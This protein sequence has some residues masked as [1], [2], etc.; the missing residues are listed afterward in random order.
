MKEVD[1][2]GLQLEPIQNVLIVVLGEQDEPK[3]LLPMVIGPSE[4]GAIAQAIA[5]SEPAR[6]L[7]HDLLASVTRA[8]GAEVRSAE[9]TQQSDGTFLAELVV[10]N[11]AGDDR[12]VD[13][14]PS[15]AI[16]VALRCRAPVLVNEGVLDDSGVLPPVPDD[17]TLIDDEVERFRA[18]LDEIDPEAF[19]SEEVPPAPNPTGDDLDHGPTPCGDDP[20]DDAEPR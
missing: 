17:D 19:G 2:V 4:A 8:V 6:P 13:A 7:T 20:T 10:T 15:D 18:F 5:G 16:A 1:V 9:I 3:R 12:R 14:R 11:A